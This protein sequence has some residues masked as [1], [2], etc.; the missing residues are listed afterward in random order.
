MWVYAKSPPVKTSKFHVSMG[1][2]VINDR[3]PRKVEQIWWLHTE[4]MTSFA[5]EPGMFEATK[6]EID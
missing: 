5:N 4:W 1:H 3:V 6:F 2:G